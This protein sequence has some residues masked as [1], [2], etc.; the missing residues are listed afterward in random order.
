MA[1]LFDLIDPELKLSAFHTEGRLRIFETSHLQSR[2]LDFL[3][4][5]SLAADDT[6]LFSCALRYHSLSQW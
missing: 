1:V 2:T 5:F 4:T 3:F 6:K